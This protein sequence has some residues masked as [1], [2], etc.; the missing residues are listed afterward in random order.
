MRK[1]N[2][3]RL[4]ILFTL[5]FII[6]FIT[7]L[8]FFVLPKF[9]FMYISADKHWQK[10]KIGDGDEKTGG[11]GVGYVAQGENGVYFI[12]KNRLMYIDDK[13]ENIKEV[14]KDTGMIQGGLV[15]GDTVFLY[16]DDDIGWIN[17]VDSSGKI[18]R[19]IFDSGKS[20]IEGKNIYTLNS[21]YG[22]RKY[23]FNGNRISSNKVKFDVAS[24]NTVFDN[25][26]FYRGY[27]GDVD[28]EVSIPKYYLFD[29]NK[30]KYK[31]RKLKLS[32]YYLQPEAGDIYW[33]EDGIPYDSFAKELDK[34]VREGKIFDDTAEKNLDDYELQSVELLPWSFS[35]V[36]DG[37]IYLYGEQKVTYRDK[38]YKEKMSVIKEEWE[39]EKIKKV[40]YTTIARV[41]CRINIE[42]IKDTSEDTYIN[43]ERV[44]YDLDKKWGGFIINNKNAYVLK[45]DE[46]FDSSKEDRNIYVYSMDVDTGL[47]KEIY[48]KERFFIGNY[49][50]EMF[51]TDK[52][53]FIYEGSEYGVK[54]CITRIDRDGNNPVLVMDEN[55]EVVMQALEK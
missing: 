49:Y 52:Y 45:E 37:Y 55:G 47:Y 7:V 3:L 28:V 33:K 4:S 10:E 46:Y 2:K 5:F 16:K 12:Y 51:V 32:K 13:Y 38:N 15:E 36:Q 24:I 8:I 1:K 53:I 54:E 17:K 27:D 23:D 22:L 20:Y 41:L 26:I 19:F 6:I 39:S 43:Y 11:K 14:C 25:Y 29:V 30:I 40:T 34:T 9:D 50:S 35:E 44:C 42:D 31:T 48:R 18:V 21:K